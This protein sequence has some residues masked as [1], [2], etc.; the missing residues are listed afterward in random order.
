MHKAR[1][2]VNLRKPYAVNDLAMQECLLDRRVVLSIL[3]AINVP[4][5]RRLCV[6]RDGGPHLSDEVRAKV[7]RNIGIDVCAPVPEEEF[8]V[9][10]QD[11]ISVGGKIMK[12]P[13]VEKPVDG[14]DHRIH[15]YFDT[16]RGGGSRK[17]FRKVIYFCPDLGAL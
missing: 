10:D 12:K 4:T 3:D 5:P 15:I 16:T 8:V 17:L 6:S 9:V 7:L 11:T 14:E 2:Y 1:H 13:F